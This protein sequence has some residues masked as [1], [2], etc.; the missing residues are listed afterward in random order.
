M[1]LYPLYPFQRK[2]LIL[3]L[4]T[5]WVVYFLYSLGK[6]N[7]ENILQFQTNDPICLRK[8]WPWSKALLMVAVC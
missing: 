6:N 7:C 3:I 5:I 4:G 1:F 8:Y 2:N